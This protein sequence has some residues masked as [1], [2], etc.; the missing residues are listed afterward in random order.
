MATPSRKLQEL[1]LFGYKSIRELRNLRLDPGL[2]VLIGANGSGKTNFIKFFELLGHMMDPSKGLQNYVNQR[3]RADAF[4]FRGP[5][6]TPK[7]R[8]DFKFGVHR[9]DFIL[10]AADDHSL[11]IAVDLAKDDQQGHTAVGMLESVF[12]RT[13]APDEYRWVADTIQDWRVYHFH[14]TTASAR[15]MGLCN[16]VDNRVLHSDAANLAAFLW[17][18]QQVHPRSL[19]PDR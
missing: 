11:Y 18:I 10:H 13:R 8:A 6:V 4:L 1:S 7:L 16:I 5:K 12:Q 3:G 2:N 9:Y 17:R 14:D 19:R 15:V